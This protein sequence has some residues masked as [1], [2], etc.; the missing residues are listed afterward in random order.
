M[1]LETKL[2]I[3]M[4]NQ[5]LADSNTVEEAQRKLEL[6]A[7]VESIQ[8]PKLGELRALHEKYESEEK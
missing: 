8:L 1:S 4:F 6:I 7:S 3:A 5:I 2:L